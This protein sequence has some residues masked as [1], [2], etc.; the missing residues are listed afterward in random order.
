MKNFVETS[1]ES[2]RSQVGDGRVICGLSGGVDSAV[3]AAL[4]SR[5]IGSR[6]TCIFVDTGLMRKNEIDSVAK[7]FRENFDANLVV[8]DAEERFL[9]LLKDVDDPQEK[10]KI[11]GKTFIDV[12]T[13]EAHKVDGAKFLA[14]GTIWPDVVE[15]GGEEG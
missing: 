5:A 15:S 8:V 9:S 14:Q 12:F 6:L 10:R 4:V 11:I 13:E 7:V 2:I 3:V 1:I